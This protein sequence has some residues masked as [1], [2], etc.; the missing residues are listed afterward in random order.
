M[1]IPLFYA[2]FTSTLLLFAPA[3]LE[4]QGATAQQQVTQTPPNR[5]GFTTSMGLPPNWRWSMGATVG[6]HRRDGNE[7]AMY[8]SGGFYKTS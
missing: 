1:K 4:V 5:G 3:A 6:T 7:V 8:F 2:V